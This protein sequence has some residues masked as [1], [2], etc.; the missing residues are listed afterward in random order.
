MAC[1]HFVFSCFN[2]QPH[3][4]GHALVHLCLLLVN[5]WL[6]LDNGGCY[7]ENGVKMTDGR[8]T[9]VELTYAM[10][11]FNYPV[12]LSNLTNPKNPLNEV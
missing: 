12:V 4:Y 5:S 1:S 3:T 9:D 6:W 11:M 8:V 7:S 2:S 10:I